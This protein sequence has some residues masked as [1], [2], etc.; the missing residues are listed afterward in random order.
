M[1]VSYI[2]LINHCKK[3][4]RSYK[5][6]DGCGDDGAEIISWSEFVGLEGLSTLINERALL[7]QKGLKAM[8]VKMDNSQCFEID[9]YQQSSIVI[10]KTLGDFLLSLVKNKDAVQL[11]VVQTTVSAVLTYI[12]YYVA[13]KGYG[14]ILRY[15]GKKGEIHS[16]FSEPKVKY[17][18]IVKT[19]QS[20]D[21]LLCKILESSILKIDRQPISLDSF[22]LLA[23]K[24]DSFVTTYIRKIR[25]ELPLDNIVII[26]PLR[27]KA[28]FVRANNQGK[29]VS[30]TQWDQLEMIG[31][32][33][34]V[35]A[36]EA[37]RKYGAG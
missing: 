22:T 17:P 31:Q 30:K 14:C 37:S 27:L 10:G 8:Q 7:K 26:E 16:L 3:V 6:D 24:G 2:E 35:Q 29:T 28:N 20:T 32:R 36:T 19:D 4:F 21:Q 12:P 18:L 23:F 34:L 15:V 33:C 9:A 25:N 1:R 5:I 13:K 11:N